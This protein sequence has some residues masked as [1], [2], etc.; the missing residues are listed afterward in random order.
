MIKGV[1]KLH[2]E[3]VTSAST[4]LSTQSTGIID[5][6]KVQECEANFDTV[7]TEPAIQSVLVNVF[8]RNCTVLSGLACKNV[9]ISTHAHGFKLEG[10]DN[11]GQAKNV[12]RFYPSK[13][14]LVDNSDNSEE[15]SISISKN[16]IEAC[17]GPKI[18]KI[19]VENAIIKWVSKLN[20][21][22][23]HGSKID[24][25]SEAD[26]PVKLSGPIGF[27]GR[28]EIFIQQK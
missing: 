10:I 12:Q 4:G 9:T 14:R 28:F 8:S 24:V 19:S 18:T 7:F 21:I 15:K 20:N 23:P 11:Y 25:Y 2:Y 13:I 5:V 1:D 27:Y 16:D 26:K 6:K 17:I 22:S 3:I